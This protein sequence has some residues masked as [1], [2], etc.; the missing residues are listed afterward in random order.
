MADKKVTA[1]GANATPS[2]DDLIHLINDPS[3]TPDNQKVALSSLFKDIA[4]T[5]AE[6]SAGVTPTDLRYEPGNVLRYG[7]VADNTTDSTAAINNAIAAAA[8]TADSGLY[9]TPVIFPPADDRYRCGDLDP[10]VYSDVIMTGATIEAIT[11]ATTV[12]NL[13]REDTDLWR[14]RTFTGGYIRGNGRA[15]DGI[16]F[17]D[18]GNTGASDGPEL[19]GRWAFHGTF[20]ENCNRAIYKP[21]GNLGNLFYNVTTAACNFGY[22]AKDSDS[23]NIMHPGMDQFYGGHHSHHKKAAMY[24]SSDTQNTV[25][26]ILDGVGFEDNVAFA[27]YFDGWNLAGTALQLRSLTFENNNT[28]SANV[29]LGQGQGSEAPRDIFMRDVDYAI[30]TGC[31][32]RSQG[33]GFVNSQVDLSGC[34]TDATSVLSRDSNSVVRFKDANLNGIDGSTDVIVE[35]LTQQRKNSGNDGVTMVAQIP[36]RDKIV[37]SLPG[38]GVGVFS[39]THN[40]WSVD[41]GGAITG[42]RTKSSGLLGTGLYQ[43]HNTITLGADTTYNATDLIPVLAN[44]WYVY[45]VN[46][47]VASGEV[48]LLDFAGTSTHELAVNLDSPL[49]DNV[50]DGDWVTIGGVT[51]FTNSDGS[52]NTRFKFARTASTATVFSLGPVQVV[53]FNTQQ[54]AIDYFNSRAFYQKQRFEYSGLAATSSGTVAIDFTDEGFQDQPDAKY[55]IEMAA[56]GD[57]N[58]FYSSK[59][60]TGFTINNGAGTN[61]VNWRVYR[62]DL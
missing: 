14:Y 1:M 28:G 55:N 46:I 33:W 38:T 51:E 59:L 53:Q 2:S 11:G 54:E 34:F 58:L 18:D 24:W 48:N 8:T 17:D 7:A 5:A 52:G 3:G 23:P 32:V 15:T 4:V 56:D 12:F 20:F 60:T 29:D 41:F 30:I 45:T 47:M 25:G 10:I 43:H 31:H 27:I 37:T 42:V 9:R 36:A 13:G 49:R 57:A 61:G 6:T 16:T 22:F 39:E 44:K 21:R 50:T 35:S 62:R 19:A 26:T 40:E